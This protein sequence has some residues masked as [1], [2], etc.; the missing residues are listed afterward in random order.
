MRSIVQVLPNSQQHLQIEA[1]RSQF[2]LCRHRDG[3]VTYLRSPY[4]PT[5]R[6][7]PWR[8]SQRRRSPRSA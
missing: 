5:P 3:V 2:D 7:A 6:A 4:Y 8:A 1:D